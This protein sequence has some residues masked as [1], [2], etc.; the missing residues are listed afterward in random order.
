SF[1]IDAFSDPTDAVFIID[2]SGSMYM[3]TLPNGQTRIAA[4]IDGLNM[5]IKLLMDAN[6]DNRVA[7]V[8]FGGTAAPPTMISLGHYDL[9]GSNTAY[10][11]VTGSGSSTTLVVN[12]AN[13]TSADGAVVTPSVVVGG[14]TPTQRG[15]Y[16]GAQILINNYDTTFTTSIGTTVVRKPVMILFTDGEPTYGWTDYK[17]VSGSY[18]CGNGANADM[19]IDL[20]CVA[21]ASY[22]KQM[23]HDHY[24][25]ADDLMDAARYYTI[26]LGVDSISSNAVLDP[27]TGAAANSY[28][29]SGTTYNMKTLL[30][31]FVTVTPG[32]TS[33]TFPAV[34]TGGSVRRLVTIQNTNN[35]VQ[36]YYYTD[37]YFMAD[38]AGALEEAFKSITSQIITEG[39][40]VTQTGPNPDFDGYITFSDV[41]GQYMRFEHL[42]G[43]WLDNNR[44]TGASFAQDMSQ[45]PSSPNWA[46]FTTNLAIQMSTPAVTVSQPTAASIV[47]SSIAGGSLYYDSNTDYSNCIKWYADNHKNYVSPYYDASG[48]VISPPSG[49]ECLMELYPIEGEATNSVTGQTTVLTNTFVAVLTAL[50]DGAFN[51]DDNYGGTLGGLER[52]LI[53]GQQIVRWYIPAS[54]I[55]MRTVSPTYGEDQN[56]TGMAI[57]EATPIHVIYSIGLRDPFAL[58]NVNQDYKDT[59]YLTAPDAYGRPSLMP[60]YSNAFQYNTTQNRAAAFCELS[61]TNPY[62][63]HWDASGQIPLFVDTGGGFVP[64]TASDTGPFYTQAEYF[65]INATPT[66]L[67]TDYVPVATGTPISHD[68]ATGVPYIASGTPVAVHIALS[69]DKSEN[70]T[71]TNPYQL[72]TSLMRPISEYSDIQ[73]RFHDNN[74]LL[75]V[76]DTAITVQ[77]VWDGMDPVPIE[78]QLYEKES[79]DGAEVAV[80]PPVELS[81]TNGWEYT[82]EDLLVYTIEPDDNGD[83]FFYEYTVAESFITT[84]TQG[85]TTSYEQPQWDEESG[86]WSDAIITNTAGEVPPG[87]PVPPP[88]PPPGPEDPFKPQTPGTGDSTKGWSTLVL[89]VVLVLGLALVWGTRKQNALR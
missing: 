86:T 31:T 9:T 42:Y 47:Q 59:H 50:H 48:N 30:D 10:F 88:G 89:S 68:S 79:P 77:K 53:T 35:F 32:G 27:Q 6:P 1:T 51:Y 73:L 55:P 8:A 56:L 2:I 5:A 74:G 29:Y 83:A 45:G 81:A 71:N 14:G 46:T 85:F 7:V 15:M 63:Y 66:Y 67:V 33:I 60:F 76:P 4:T 54:L 64:A 57:R 28:T 41:N 80:G 11:S 37:D 62:Y 36:T 72:L 78:V 84:P 82:W 3:Y 61:H 44:F 12:S 69:I 17:T 34:N 65:D 19:G 24:Y 58:S 52:T 25:G 40:Y 16:A 49:A 22:W 39:G 70:I 87:P 43:I 21:T 75:G 20:L 13:F 26:G 38:D 23:V 18:D